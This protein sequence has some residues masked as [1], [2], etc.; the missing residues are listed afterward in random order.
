MK[1]QLRKCLLLVAL[2]SGALVVS[3]SD[4]SAC[5]R[6]HHWSGCYSHTYSYPTCYSYQ[7]RYVNP[8][9]YSYQP[10]YVYPTTYRYQ[11]QY[12][13]PTN[14]SHRVS[15]GCSTWRGY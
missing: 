9:A 7:P 6:R 5:H 10:Q 8:T 4:A 15:Y 2:A 12:V 1:T 14:Y 13:Y 11:P 3:A